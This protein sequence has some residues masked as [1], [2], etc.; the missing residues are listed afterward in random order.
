M[1]WGYLLIIVSKYAFVLSNKYEDTEQ[2]NI[3]LEFILGYVL[4][5]LNI[6]PRMNKVLFR[7]T[8]QERSDAEYL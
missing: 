5:R 3:P 6:D 7:N 8:F 1:D 2:C 4:P